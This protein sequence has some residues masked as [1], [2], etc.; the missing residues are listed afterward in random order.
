VKVVSSSDESVVVSWIP[1]DHPNGLISSYTLY[2]R[3][4]AILEHALRGQGCFQNAL[5]KL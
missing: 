5:Q 1:P 2:K 4:F 3:C